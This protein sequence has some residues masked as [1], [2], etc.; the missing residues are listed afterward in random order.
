MTFIDIELVSRGYELDAE[1]LVPPHVLL[2]YMEHLRWEYVGRSPSEVKALFR[3]GHTFVVIAQTLRITGGIGLAAAI[4]GTL[5]IGRIGRTSMDF[6]HAFQRVK[7]GE[8]LAEGVATTVYVDG[9]GSPM[10]IPALLGVVHPD[11]PTTMDL[12]PPDFCAMPA[13]SFKH[14]CRVRAD[15]LDLLQHMNQANYAALYDDARQAAAAEGAYGP[16]GLGG[17]RVRFL[18]IGIQPTTFAMTA[19]NRPP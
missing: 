6:H 3:K 16:D 5:W 14:S 10:P 19:S 1:G 2:R 13:G 15:D 9:N 8:I 7:N 17:G 18:H 4:R 11:P 12:K